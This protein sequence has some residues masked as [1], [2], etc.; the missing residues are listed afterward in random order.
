M[1]HPAARSL[2]GC[3]KEGGIN[4]EDIHESDERM[5]KQVKR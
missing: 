4:A 2:S 3:S 1:V 5:Y